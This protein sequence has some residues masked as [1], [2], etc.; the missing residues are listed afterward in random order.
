MAEYRHEFHAQ[1]RV[2]I[3][4]TVHGLTAPDLVVLV[5]NL[6]HLP[7][8]PLRHPEHTAHLLHYEHVYLAAGSLDVEVGFTTPHSGTVILVELSE[9][10]E[11][12]PCLSGFL[13]EACLD[14]PAVQIQPAPWGGEMGVCAAC[15]DDRAKS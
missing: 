15:L 2:A 3:P 8:G 11:E 12:R 5:L 13:C 10:A 4:A 9:A 1:C 14:A 6:C 7:P